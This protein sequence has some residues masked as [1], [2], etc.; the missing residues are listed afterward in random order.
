M[1]KLNFGKDSVPSGVFYDDEL[2]KSA[3]KIVAERRAY[4]KFES[5]GKS[6]GKGLCG[7]EPATIESANVS[8]TAYTDILSGPRLV[9]PPSLTSVDWSNDGAND[10]IDAYLWKATVNFVCYSPGQFNSFDRAFFQHFN[11]VKLTLGWINYGGSITITGTIVDFQ[12]TINEKLQYECSVTFAGAALESAAAF[13]LNL[14][15]ENTKHK[16]GN[17]SPQTIVGFLKAQAIKN[18]K[19][20]EPDVGLGLAKGDNSY[21]IAKIKLSETNWLFWNKEKVVYYVSLKH[22]IDTINTNLPKDGNFKGINYDVVSATQ[23]TPKIK[24]ANPLNVLNQG[25][26]GEAANYA[27]EGANFGWNGGDV[28]YFV[29]F[30]F[31]E[32]IEYDSPGDKSDNPHATKNTLIQFIRKVLDEI[33]NCLGDS[34][35]LELIPYGQSGEGIEHGYEITDRKTLIQNLKRLTIVNPL[36]KTAKIRN[37]NIQSTIDSEI[38]AIALS[39]AQSGDKQGVVQGVFGCTPTLPKVVQHKQELVNM[40]NTFSTLDETILNECIQTLKK[41]CNVQLPQQIGYKYGVTLTVTVD[42]Y[43]QHLF[44]KAF[45]VAGLPSMLRASNVYFII[46]KQSHKFDN[47]DWTMDLEGQMMFDISDNATI[48]KAF[49]PIAGVSPTPPVT[50]NLTAAQIN[51]INEGDIGF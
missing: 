30:D 26:G 14:K 25:N 2:G 33:N 15:N 51:E 5:T 27:K 21:G 34:I 48:P 8:S 20:S 11:E 40:Y 50:R 44:G 13:G 9:P 37:I 19:G 7:A 24:S 3:S 23:V 43:G 45:K 1:S 35:K 6:T 32:K 28:P 41:I 16:I 22:L 46:L 49:D 36:N 38:A 4:A 47:G 39:S 10:I 31:L 12:F 18:L 42:G 17:F 29:S